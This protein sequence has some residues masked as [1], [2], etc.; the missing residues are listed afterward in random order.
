VRLL[1]RGSMGEVWI[2]HHKTLG[3]DVAI[4]LLAPACAAGE[5]E[6][7]PTASARFRFEAQVAGRLS[8][9][10]RHIVRVTDHGEEEGHA[11]AYLVM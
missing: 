4:K 1:G 10:T 3:E 11:P 6:S 2:A 9:H 7:Y 8:R 5:I